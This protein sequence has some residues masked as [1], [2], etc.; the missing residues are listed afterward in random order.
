MVMAAQ[1]MLVGSIFFWGRWRVRSAG[2]GPRSPDLRVSV[3]CVSV[4]R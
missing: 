2:V 4:L 1:D 3:L